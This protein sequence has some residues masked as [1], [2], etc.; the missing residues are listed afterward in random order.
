MGAV[1]LLCVP[2]HDIIGL[3]TME[4][5]EFVGLSKTLIRPT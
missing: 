2:G 4:E 3:V 1:Q 5:L